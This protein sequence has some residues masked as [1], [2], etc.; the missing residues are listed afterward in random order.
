MKTET[1][2]YPLTFTL[3]YS[4]YRMCRHCGSI[5]LFD[6]FDSTDFSE[7]FRCPNCGKLQYEQKESLPKGW[8]CPRCGKVNSP[9][10]QECDCMI[11]N[12][13]SVP[14]TTGGY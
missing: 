2:N 4:G 7:S 10:V 5:H 1:T 6:L 14:K 12:S 13:Y 3:G 9:F 8:I 11:I